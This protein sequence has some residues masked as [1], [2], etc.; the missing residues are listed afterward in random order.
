MV[1]MVDQL[2]GGVGVFSWIVK[3]LSTSSGLYGTRLVALNPFLIFSIRN[4]CFLASG[5][6][7][8][9]NSRVRQ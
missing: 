5:L 6:S 2:P 8:M 7:W 9:C 1:E 3:R 4:A